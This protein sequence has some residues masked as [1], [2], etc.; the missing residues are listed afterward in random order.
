VLI[1]IIWNIFEISSIDKNPRVFSFKENK[2][3]MSDKK[4]LSHLRKPTLNFTPVVFGGNFDP[5]LNQLNDQKYFFLCITI[6]Y[7]IF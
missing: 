7:D 5:I 4:E 2:I 1:I 3:T 6:N